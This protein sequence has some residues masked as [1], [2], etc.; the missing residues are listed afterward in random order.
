MSWTWV[1]LIL[2][3]LSIVAL[4]FGWVAWV[5]SKEKIANS[6]PKTIPDMLRSSERTEEE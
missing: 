4:L 3:A 6:Y 1:V 2:G 5:G